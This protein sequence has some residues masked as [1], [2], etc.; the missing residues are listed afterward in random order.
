M[1]SLNW[2]GT[3]GQA[4]AKDSIYLGKF[5]LRFSTS[6]KVWTELPNGV[7]DTHHSNDT[8]SVMM[9]G[10]KMSGVYKIGGTNPDFT[11]IAAA[12]NALASTGVCG[13]VTFNINPGTYSESVDI[14]TITG[15]S[16]TNTI[17]FKSANNDSTSVIIDYSS[18]IYS[19][20][21]NYV[22]RLSGSYITFKHVTLVQH[23]PQ[24]CSVI[25]LSKGFNNVLNCVLRSDSSGCSL[26][27]SDATSGNFYV[28]NCVFGKGWIGMD[29]HNSYVRTYVKNCLFNNQG[30][31][32][33]YGFV[34][35]I[36]QNIFNTTSVQNYQN[37]DVTCGIDTLLIYG[38]KITSTSGTG[39]NI[40]AGYVKIYNNYINIQNDLISSYSTAAI[41]INSSSGSNV[42]ANIYN[43]TIFFKDNTAASAALQYQ[44]NQNTNC[45]VKNNI[46]IN[47]GSNFLY[48]VSATG[49]TFISDSNC[50]YSNASTKMFFYNGTYYNSFYSYIA[51]GKDVHSIYKI[52]VF[53]GS[54]TY[55]IAHDIDLFQKGS[56]VTY[57]TKDIDNNPRSGNHSCIGAH[58]F[59][60]LQ[61]DAYID[62][63]ALY[64]TMLCAG[65][66]NL[67]VR[68]KNSGTDTL[69]SVNFKWKINSGPLQSYT[70]N[71]A[72]ATGDSVYATIGIYNASVFN[73]NT[74]IAYVS[75][76]NGTNDLNHLND[77]V[78]I[79]KNAHL[80]GTYKIGGSGADFATFNSAI[81]TLSQNGVCGPVD[82]KIANGTYVEHFTITPVPGV[83]AVNTITFESVSGDSS[84]V[85]LSDSN[86]YMA[87]INCPYVT[88]KKLGFWNKSNYNYATITS[89][90]HDL[91]ISNCYFKTYLGGN[92]INSSY[93]FG[94]I[95]MS[96]TNNYFESGG[97]YVLNANAIYIDN[98]NGKHETVNDNTIKNF[99]GAIQV[100][101]ADSITVKRNIITY[102]DPYGGYG[103]SAGSSGGYID[104]SNNTI[105]GGLVAIS[106][107]G[108]Y[109]NAINKRIVKNNFC[110]TN[111][112]VA[113]NLDN[114]SNVQVYFNTFNSN[115]PNNDV[116]IKAYN[117][118]NNIIKNN[119]LSTTGRGSL[120]SDIPTHHNIFDFNNYYTNGDTIGYLLIPNIYVNYSQWQQTTHQDHNSTTFKPNYVSPADLH[121]NNDLNLNNKG[122]SISGIT[123]DYDGDIRN[124]PP[125]IG[126][127]EI[128][129]VQ[130]PNDASIQFDGAM[131]FCG[132]GNTPVTVKL[133]NNGN[134]TL[135]SLTINWLINGTLQTPFNWSGTLLPSDYVYVIIGNLPPNI[136]TNYSLTAYSDN[137]NGATDSYPQNDTTRFTPLRSSLSGTYSIGGSSADFNKIS[138]AA[139]YLKTYG[140]C[141]PV[142][143]NINSG[144]YYED[145]ELDSVQGTSLTNTITFQSPTNNFNNVYIH[146]VNSSDYTL[147]LIGADHITFKHLT[148]TSNPWGGSVMSYS[149]GCDYLTFDSVQL[150][151]Q[152]PVINSTDPDY[153]TTFT[154]CFLHTPL[155]IQG[156]SSSAPDKGFTFTNCSLFARDGLSIYNG[157]SITITGNRFICSSATSN[158]NGISLKA[159]A[160]NIKVAKNYIQG[161]FETGINLYSVAGTSSNHILIANNSVAG[162]SSSLYN[163][164][165]NYCSYVDFIY[166]SCVLTNTVTSSSYS[167]FFT[168]YGNNLVLFNN[169]FNNAGGGYA[170]N[171]YNSGQIATSDYNIYNTSGTQIYYNYTSG[172]LV[173]YKTT[174]SKDAHSTL[175]DPQYYSSTDLHYNNTSLNGLA[176]PVPSV[177][178]DI[179]NKIRSATNPNPGAF[180][181][182]PDTIFDAVNKDLAVTAETSSLS[183]GSNTISIT[184]TNDTIQ[185]YDPYH[186]YTAT[187]DSVD[188]SYKVNDGPWINQL[189]TGSL[190][191]NQSTTYTF[192][193]PYNV[194]KGRIYYL[195]T[196]AKI[197]SS[198]ITDINLANDSLRKQINLPMAGV[199][200]VGGTNPDFTNGDTA[201]HDLKTCH[202][203][204]PVTFSFRPGNYTLWDLSGS[205]TLTVRSE[206]GINSDVTLDCDAFFASNC[207]FKKVT[208]ATHITNYGGTYPYM[209]LAIL[210]QN[211]TVDS[212][213]IVGT[214]A[215]PGL[216]N[217]FA[218]YT[219]SDITITN[220]F[221]KHLNIGLIYNSEQYIF[222]GGGSW[223]PH[224]T[225]ANNTFDS[226]RT[227]FLVSLSSSYAINPSDSIRFRNNIIT[228][229]DTGIA[230]LS[231]TG[232]IVYLQ[233][234]NNKV[235][236]I[237]NALSINYTGLG[238]RM[239]VSN[240]FFSGGDTVS[241]FYVSGPVSLKSYSTVSINYSRNQYFLNNSIHGSVS[242]VQ[243]ANTFFMNNSVFSDTLLALVA[244]DPAD[245]TGG[246]NNLYTNGPILAYAGMYALP[247]INLDS[248]KKYF[249]SELNSISYNPYYYS[250]TD[251]HS[252]SPFLKGKAFP[253]MNIHTDI[254]GQTRNATTP[255]IGADEITL[256]PDV[257]WPGDA[258][259]S[260]KVDNTDFLSIGLYNG[261]SGPVRISAD[262]SWSPHI[263]TNWNL[264]QYDSVDYKHADCN[265]DGIIDDNDTLAI[266][267]NYSLTHSTN[268]RMGQPN[269]ISSLG[270]DLYFVMPYPKS[271][272]NIGDTILA[273]IWFGHPSASISNAYGIAFSIYTSAESILP[274]S[275]KIKMHD[276]WMGT[277]N[278]NMYGF[279]KTHEDIGVGEGVVVRKDHIN[280]AGYGSIG[281]MYFI[282]NGNAPSQGIPLNFADI[283][284][285]D[286]AGNE[287]QANGH[288][289]NAN[290]YV[291]FSGIGIKEF[292]SSSEG[293]ASFPNPFSDNT[294]ITY[295]LPYEDNIK[296]EIFD[297]LERL[298]TTAVSKKLPKGV[299]YYNF[300]ATTFGLRSGVYSAKLSRTSKVSVIRLIQTE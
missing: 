146:G 272:Y 114:S 264:T 16:A 294:T 261:V 5:P 247:F 8:T 166:N 107:S 186:I 51:S 179:Q 273:E 59:S 230:V 124:N 126:A 225:I 73:P 109:P 229:S 72:L 285:V 136:V 20:T 40:G 235:S 41:T 191:P 10:V 76:V 226:V 148:F 19:S 266:V 106:V 284:F 262:N 22:I 137:P 175:L 77:T 233:V 7:N 185:N 33:I 188:V 200:Y 211:I 24:G 237:K 149:M 180:E 270:N 75:L 85:T 199:Y 115:N 205:D 58:E 243:S 295:S 296:L 69:H 25:Y 31:Y 228:N 39:I 158:N 143:F 282:Y 68:L 6:I 167:P 299:Y 138:D 141:G 159:C 80:S 122:I 238:P 197:H 12:K 42:F 210:G 265:G 111:G 108:L 172:T 71:G 198:T 128:N 44:T 83:S 267:Q 215:W 13:P 300:N 216:S 81:N 165:C 86:F 249:A 232:G 97:N 201:F 92:A 150:I 61:T 125:D 26:I 54:S 95:N 240:N 34:T 190:G 15:A 90:T 268:V 181:T 64:D 287:I 147:K 32:G 246:H 89:S 217:G 183:I 288:N 227:A 290:N 2:T 139:T 52:P 127:D 214:P 94:N 251:L 196:K 263:S 187:I 142:V 36:G 56:K 87:T 17:T 274:G 57:I 43:N 271:T 82:F 49:G 14:P 144:S 157:D 119:I 219:S 161:P 169:I 118:N 269:Q 131:T 280:I 28:T 207:T 102:S 231:N 248:I 223:G 121:L 252:N 113:L 151:G 176:T 204:A 110:N 120:I 55:L 257:V 156:N 281:T 218:V 182:A 29:M 18:P 177:S 297:E 91:N 170:A 50:F 162:A 293:L 184:F 35:E 60:L 286:A 278:A 93:N 298:V 258:N 255:D 3:L 206:S 194:P 45:I 155:K 123:T 202:E 1:A 103:I 96:V 145:I 192:T 132:S 11:T 129:P 208:V 277:L 74:I 276:S 62:K 163:I 88:L 174:T 193:V 245:L 173:W 171:F 209:G 99:G 78:T 292:S 259:A 168:I 189:W 140:V 260:S 134:N 101:C 221:F 178:D 224:H 244:Y 66:Y 48:N 4:Y 27:Y 84:L 63:I 195:T 116:L 9:S 153:K 283:T 242:I 70:W 250:T 130:L 104:I 21:S 135:S 53:A 234:N 154:N 289:N 67:N 212:C 279:A 254:D 100:S 152:T 133:F 256:V 239:M 65:N 275:F 213:I 236:A 160:N 241:L 30:G 37:L 253:F 291:P 46:I 164:G 112:T 98:G 79:T 203:S 220:N 105:S 23:S 38:N 117:S 47:Y 222:G